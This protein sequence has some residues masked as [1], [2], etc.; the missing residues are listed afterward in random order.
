MNEPW[1][2]DPSRYG[3]LRLDEEMAWAI[4]D[5]VSDKID[6]LWDHKA[7]LPN[8]SDESYATLIEI[9]KLEKARRNI[10]G[11]M[12]EKGWG[13]NDRDES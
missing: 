10:E 11:V 7:K 13:E 12:D 9:R 6:E 8:P 3:R 4:Y 2:K 5:A 1:A